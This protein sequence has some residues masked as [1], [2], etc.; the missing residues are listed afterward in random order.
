MKLHKA[1]NQLGFTV[2][3][4]IVAVMSSTVLMAGLYQIFHSYQFNY[5]SQDNSIEM[6]QNL[7]SGIYLM[8]KDIRFSRYNPMQT[9][10]IFEFSSNLESY[11]IFSDTKNPPIDYT[12]DT[13]RIA[14]YI[15]K[16]DDGAFQLDSD[17]D[18]TDD[19][20]DDGEEGEF[21]AYRLK[22]SS[23]QRFNSEIFAADFNV[24][25]AWQ[26][27][28]TNVDAL[29]FVFI[30]DTGE[31]TTNPNEARVVQISLL[32]RSSKKDHEYTNRTIYENYQGEEIC[33]HC[34]ND[35]YHRRLIRM[36]VR[37]RNAH[38]SKANT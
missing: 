26:S 20:Y 36:T 6:Q 3:E 10:D 30:N 23:L 31:P 11:D 5:I 33:D 4:V 35:N 38:V 16:N 28:A 21:I 15:D 19:T 32:V 37:I 12:Q 22:G 17:P 7:R 34:T 27:I 8:T 9:E 25:N 13:D 29:N 2:L 18:N 1:K 24:A 14:F